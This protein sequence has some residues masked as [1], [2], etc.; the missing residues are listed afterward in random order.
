MSS[1]FR[2]RTP[3]IA[4]H[5]SALAMY[6]SDGRFTNAVEELLRNLGHDRLDTL[7]VPGGPALL[8]TTSSEYATN[9]AIRTAVT[10]LIRGH[11]I[12]QVTLIAHD[13]CGYYRARLPYESPDS[14]RRRQETDLRSA[15]RWVTNEHPGVQ[16]LMFRAHI[17]EG[18]VAFA[19]I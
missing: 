2:A 19:R 6:C 16:V 11:H 14:M 5:P 4:E 18:H 17:V 15:A 10:F 1:E 9:N 3:Y 8:D 7:T 13:G 12:Q